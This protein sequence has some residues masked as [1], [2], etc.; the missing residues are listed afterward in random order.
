MFIL[1][2]CTTNKVLNTIFLISFVKFKVH[3]N[4]RRRNNCLTIIKVKEICTVILLYRFDLLITNPLIDYSLIGQL[5]GMSF[6]CSNN[7][8]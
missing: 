5:F 1:L 3:K 2:Q 7:E 8:L 4:N 6:Y